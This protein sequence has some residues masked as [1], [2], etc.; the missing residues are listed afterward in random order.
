M[1]IRILLRGIGANAVASLVRLLRDTSGRVVNAA[2]NRAIV[3][4]PGSMGDSSC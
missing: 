3:L 4:D 2:L 1:R